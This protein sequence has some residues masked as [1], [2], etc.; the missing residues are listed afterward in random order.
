ME[1]APNNT[2]KIKKLGDVPSNYTKQIGAVLYYLRSLMD[3]ALIK[4]FII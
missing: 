3:S 1:C 2:R 4:I